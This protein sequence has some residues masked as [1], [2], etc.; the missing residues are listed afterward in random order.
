M[1]ER[2]CE[3]VCVS[4]SK[5]EERL[6]SIAEDRDLQV[7][8]RKVDPFSARNRPPRLGAEMI[9]TAK[10]S[11]STV[12]TMPAKRPSSRYTRCPTCTAAKASG[13]SHP[14]L[15]SPAIP[16]RHGVAAVNPSTIQIRSPTPRTMNCWTLGNA[17]T[18]V[19]SP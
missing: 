4:N 2:H 18:R 15:G 1:D 13:V 16:C 6:V 14:M 10:R 12:S 3:H 5:V 8:V 7:G 9:R 19:S 17:P 11:G